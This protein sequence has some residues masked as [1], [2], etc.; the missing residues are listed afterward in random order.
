MGASRRSVPDIRATG[1]AWVTEAEL[2]WLCDLAESVE[3]KPIT[4]AQKDEEAES[5]RA[6]SYERA[7]M[8]EHEE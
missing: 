4:E 7:V 5:E 2:A 3:R 8:K 6:W 1:A